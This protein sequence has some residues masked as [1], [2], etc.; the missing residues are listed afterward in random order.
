LLRHNG[1]A[2]FHVY[3]DPDYHSCTALQTDRRTDGQTHSHRPQMDDI[4]MPI[5]D[6]TA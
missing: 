2:T 5:A 3:T 6:Q 4:V 1:G